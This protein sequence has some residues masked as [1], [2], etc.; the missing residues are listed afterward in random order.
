MLRLRAPSEDGSAASRVKTPKGY[1]VLL[2]PPALPPHTVERPSGRVF[3]VTL[4]GSGG[5]RWR[6]VWEPGELSWGSLAPESDRQVRQL[7]FSGQLT[8]VPSPPTRF[9]HHPPNL[10]PL[11]SV[12]ALTGVSGRVWGDRGGHPGGGTLPSLQLL[13]LRVSNVKS[14]L[15]QGRARGAPLLRSESSRYPRVSLRS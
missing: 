13:R 2:N 6:L 1:Q 7:P 11:I 4:R 12:S 9:N 5:L 14:A 3:R 15:R 8:F 10:N